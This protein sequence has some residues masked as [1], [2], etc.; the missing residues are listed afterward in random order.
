MHRQ[1]ISTSNDLEKENPEGR[2][3]NLEMRSHRYKVE[4]QNGDKDSLNPNVT[5]GKMTKG[6]A[7]GEKA[8]KWKAKGGKV[9]K[10]L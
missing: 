10:I 6:K 4:N 3:R 1:I 8:T 2:E 5:E 7:T 9:K